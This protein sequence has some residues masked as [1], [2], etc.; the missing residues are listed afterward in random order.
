M[1][2]LI[3]L[4]GAPGSGKSTIGELL[5]ESEGYPLIDFGWLRQGHLN[6]L[7]SN[8]SPEEEDMAWENLIFIIKNYWRHGYKNIIVTDLEEE[9]VPILT[10]AFKEKSY[11]I[12]SLVVNDDKELTKRVLGVRDSGFKNVEAALQWNKELKSRPARLNE[13]KIDN[14]HNDPVKTTKEILVLLAK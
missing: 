10:G 5:R 7:W 8:A 9:R 13:Y 2:D 1:K 6:N 3:I 11:I 4:A 12:A 14:T